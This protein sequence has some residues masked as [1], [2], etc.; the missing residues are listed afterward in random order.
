LVARFPEDG[1]MVAGLTTALVREKQAWK[2]IN[3][4]EAYFNQDSTHILVN[5]ALADAYFLDR[6]F[7]KSA[8]MYRR[9]LELGDSTF[10]TLYS[11]GMC[12]SQ[13]DS[14]NLAYKC[15][16]PALY[17]SQMQHANCAYRLGVVSVDLGSYNEGL[18][19]LN[20]AVEL[21]QPDST[22]MKAITLS[23]GEGYYLTHQYDKALEA[24]KRHLDYNPSSLA[25]YYNIG[26]I[27]AYLV[28]DIEQAK[29]Y[30]QQFLD[31]ARKEENPNAQLSEMIQKAEEVLKK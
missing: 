24:W 6:K 5:R 17:L 26:N 1:E 23:Q 16:L 20:L 9:L 30:Y 31:L 27:Y 25:T 11:A 28:N 7:E 3:Y 13:I 12:Y 21:M 10:N 2:G 4:A 29:S 19:Y 8:D 14:L 18:S 22:I 15:L